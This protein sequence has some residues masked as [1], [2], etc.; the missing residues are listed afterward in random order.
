MPDYNGTP[1]T[2]TAAS[3]SF[4]VLQR[5]TA[6]AVH[7]GLMDLERIDQLLIGPLR[8]DLAGMASEQGVPAAAL[9]VSQWSYTMMHG[10]ISLTLNNHLPPPVQDNP[11]FFESAIRAMLAQIAAD[12]RTGVAGQPGGQGLK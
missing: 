12:A 9:A 7:A 4:A 5:V 10:A 1:R 11:A 3:R 6:D 8:A 2:L